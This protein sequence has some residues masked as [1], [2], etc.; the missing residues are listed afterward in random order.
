MISFEEARRL[1]LSHVG[2]VADDRVTLDDA[3]GRVLARAV[4]A[5]GPFPPFSASAMDGYALASSAWQGDGPWTAEVVGESRMGSLPA[6]LVPGTICRI[7]TG[8]AVPE[9]A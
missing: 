3:T 1:V 8:A 2:G 7:F 5:R 6:P 4:L 9:G